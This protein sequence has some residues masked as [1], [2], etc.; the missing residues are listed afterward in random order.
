MTRRSATSTP[1]LRKDDMVTEIAEIEV[2]PGQEAEFEKTVVGT[3]DLLLAGDG[4]GG[5]RLARSVEYPSRYRL[6]ITWESVEHHL[7]FRDTTSFEE[8][9][10]VVGPYFAGAP[11]V[12]HIEDVLHR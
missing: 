9:R 5:V 12:E 8:W 11:R 2:R 7:R 1:E 4:C 6:F 10:G 3:T